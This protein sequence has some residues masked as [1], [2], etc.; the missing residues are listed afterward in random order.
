MKMKTRLFLILTLLISSS[1]SILPVFSQ[2]EPSTQLSLPDGVN[3]RLGKGS[4]NEIAYSP[5]GSLLA[6]AGSVGI[7]LYDAETLQELRLLAADV[8]GVYSVSFSPDGQTLASASQDKTVRLWDVSTGVLTSELIGHRSTVY[9]VSFSP[10]G[11]TLASG[12]EDS[13]VRLWD[14]ATGMPK[15]TLT[16]QRDS[17]YVVSFSPDGRT[18]AAGTYKGVILLWDLAPPPPEP[19][20]IVEDVNGDSIVNIQDLVAVAAALGETGETS[21]DVNNDGIV[22]IQDLVAVAA[23]LGETATS[24]P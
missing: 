19:E 22:N 24:A 17:Y 21:A 1:L 23:A 11:Q 8:G 10:D 16:E 20:R 13:T 3:A 15:S 12:S 6:V 4:I 18:L 2:Y 9:S 5:D 14:V 7:W